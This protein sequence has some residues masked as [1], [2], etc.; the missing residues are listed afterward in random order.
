MRDGNPSTNE[1]SDS[2]S[3]GCEE[4]AQYKA[5]RVPAKHSTPLEFCKQNSGEFP[6]L[7]EV[8]RLV[9]CISASSAQSERDFSSVGR[10]IID[11]HS[12]LSPQTVEA[13]E[14]IRW[15]LRASLITSDR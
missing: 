7:A 6:L 10:T 3:S 9:L 1:H 5:L 13:V 4:L 15:G 8:A 12:R 11:A 14:L 2:Q